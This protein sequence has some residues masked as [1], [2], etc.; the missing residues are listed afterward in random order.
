MSYY[1][2]LT[3]DDQEIGRM[4][5]VRLYYKHFP[6]L[7][8]HVKPDACDEPYFPR[9]ETP[10]MYWVLGCA[11]FVTC[12]EECWMK[13][14]AKSSDKFWE[15]FRCTLA[16]SDYDKKRL[17]GMI[18]TLEDDSEFDMVL[19]VFTKR[20]L[21]WVRDFSQLLAIMIRT[22]EEKYTYMA[23]E[24]MKVFDKLSDAYH[25][26]AY[27]DVSVRVG[28]R[29]R[30]YTVQTHDMASLVSVKIKKPDDG[31]DIYIEKD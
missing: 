3:L 28:G 26:G 16:L 20:V 10:S 9:R 25:S 29:K 21:L 12:L 14:G 31:K 17:T 24:L 4:N 1:L 7:D 6:H 8:K 19:E 27:A 2:N 15:S 11:D 18:K 13:H 5:V 23:D 22:R 30:K